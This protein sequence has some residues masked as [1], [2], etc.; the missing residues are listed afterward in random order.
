MYVYIVYIFKFYTIAMGDSF[1]LAK[2]PE[3]RMKNEIKWWRMH[4]LTARTIA[5]R[6]CGQQQ[7]QQITC[8][9]CSQCRT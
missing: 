6:E 3:G 9:L 7:Q 8:F 5:R 2:M 4:E 1:V